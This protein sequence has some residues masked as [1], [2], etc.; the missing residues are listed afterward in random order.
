MR[1]TRS[2]KRPVW[3]VSSPYHCYHRIAHCRDLL[4][5]SVNSSALCRL[6]KLYTISKLTNI[7]NSRILDWVEGVVKSGLV[8]GGADLN[9]EITSTLFQYCCPTLEWLTPLLC[10][11]WGIYFTI[12]S[13]TYCP[14]YFVNFFPNNRSIFLDFTKLKIRHWTAKPFRNR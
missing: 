1:V 2:V 4:S 14:A 10:S 6:N 13:K 12:P 5:L 11:A 7:S 9:P 3:I 8:G